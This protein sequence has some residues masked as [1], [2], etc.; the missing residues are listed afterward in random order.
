MAERISW[1]VL[2]VLVH[3]PPFIAFFRP[4]LLTSLYG[5]ARD[6]PGFTLLHHRAALFGLVVLACVWAAFDPGVRKLAFLLTALSMIS[7]LIIFIA[8]GQQP[9]LKT[10]ALVDA[11][12]LPFLAYVGWKAFSS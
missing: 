4:A 1:L 7:F 12:G 10:I 8:Y 2:G 11:A 6:D 9:S 5:V 3:L